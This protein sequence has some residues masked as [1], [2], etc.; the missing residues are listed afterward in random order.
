MCG[1]SRTVVAGSTSES[2]WNAAPKIERRECRLTRPRRR[3]NVRSCVTPDPRVGTVA[4]FA[5]LA[6]D[7]IFC[8]RGLRV[9][10]GRQKAVVS[11]Q[12]CAM[13]DRSE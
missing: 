5:L 10:G 7:A 1:P 11:A 6:S 12:N 2:R 13:S 9:A 8:H 4:G 3:N